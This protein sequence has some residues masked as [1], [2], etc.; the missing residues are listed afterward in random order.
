MLPQKPTD[1]RDYRAT[2]SSGCEVLT[3]STAVCMTP[4]GMQGNVYPR[5]YSVYNYI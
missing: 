3:D 1:M 2:D 5:L 4:S